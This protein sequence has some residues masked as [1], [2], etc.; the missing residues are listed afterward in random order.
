MNHWFLP[1][2][3]QPCARATK[4]SKETKT[5]LGRAW[6]EAGTSLHRP[7]PLQHVGDPASCNGGMLRRI[8]ILSAAASH[9]STLLRRGLLLC[10][11]LLWLRYAEREHARLLGR[12]S[13]GTAC[14]CRVL[15]TFSGNIWVMI[16][17]MNTPP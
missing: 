13:G 1:Q 16:H 6:G 4:C 10:G 14:F 3:S 12:G 17:Q 2:K 11:L 9:S 5:N 8:G 7:P 15:D